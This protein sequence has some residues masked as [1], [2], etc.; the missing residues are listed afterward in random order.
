[1][2]LS[3]TKPTQRGEGTRLRSHRKTVAI[4]GLKCRS[5]ASSR[6]SPPEDTVHSPRSPRPAAR[7]LSEEGFR[8]YS[9]GEAKEHNLLKVGE[10]KPAGGWRA[11]RAFLGVLL[12]VCREIRM[13]RAWKSRGHPRLSLRLA[14]A[15]ASWCPGAGRWLLSIWRKH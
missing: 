2:S 8:G 10:G 11:A 7:E 9:L 4:R 3:P 15:L 1:M 5:S 14:G 6:L 13:G 12:T